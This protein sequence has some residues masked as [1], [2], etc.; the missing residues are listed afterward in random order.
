MVE[1]DRLDYDS[2]DYS[3]SHCFW[4]EVT[5]KM[6]LNRLRA[7][8]HA[9]IFEFDFDYAEA[10]EISDV[11][12]YDTGLLECMISHNSGNHSWQQLAQQGGYDAHVDEWYNQ[13]KH[14]DAHPSPYQHAC[15]ASAVLH[16]LNGGKLDQYALDHSQAAQDLLQYGWDNSQLPH[17]C[18]AYVDDLNQHEQW[19]NLTQVVRKSYVEHT[20]CANSM[21]C[22]PSEAG[23]R[24]VIQRLLNGK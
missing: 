21:E 8:T 3:V 14:I 12:D 10:D 2:P 24:A 22:M 13:T 16:Q 6:L 20:H 15:V 4:Q 17:M 5:A 9:H 19:Q 23:D 1:H 11:T 7:N 18:D